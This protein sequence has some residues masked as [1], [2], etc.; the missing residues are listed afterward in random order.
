MGRLNVFTRRQQRFLQTLRDSNDL[1]DDVLETLRIS[2]RTLEIWGRN[3]KFARSRDSFL[4]ALGSRRELALE[5]AA[6]KGVEELGS[7]LKDP[8]KK[9]DESRVKLIL[10]VVF[11]ARSSQK[12]RWA[13]QRMLTGELAAR[14]KQGLAPIVIP[15]HPNLSPEEAARIR[16]S[17]EESRKD[18]EQNEED[19]DADDADSAG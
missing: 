8:S 14:E 12:L 10:D 4:D 17:F 16:R 13:L 9:I 7:L 15:P 5:M 1:L 19:D 11:A 3:K 18:A 2:S 6:S